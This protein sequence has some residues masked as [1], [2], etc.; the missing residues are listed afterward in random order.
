MD[1]EPKKTNM[2]KSLQNL[3]NLP[4]SKP[5]VQVMRETEFIEGEILETKTYNSVDSDF[6]FTRK[7]IQDLIRETKKTLASATELAK[8]GE[9]ARAYEVVGQL[10]KIL[11]D[12]NKDL[13]ELHQ[14][15]NRI[16]GETGK[17]SKPTVTNNSLFVGTTADLQKMLKDASTTK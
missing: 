11:S 2:E 4:E 13:L 17:S 6:E 7:N 1:E 10:T 8:L 3:F 15:K 5:I 16:N 14:K 12:A 9:S